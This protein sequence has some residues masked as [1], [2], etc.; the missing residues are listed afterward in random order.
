MIQRC[1]PLLLLIVCSTTAWGEVAVVDGTGQ[2]TA[3][4]VDG[5]VLDVQIGYRIPLTGW[6]RSLVPGDAQRVRTTRDGQRTAWT[7]RLPFG[8]GASCAVQQ[9][10]EERD[11]AVTVQMKFTADS[12]ID[13]EGIF[14]WIDIPIRQFAGGV[15]ALRQED[16][17]VRSADF[18]SEKPEQRH[19]LRTTAD[20]I[21][22]TSPTKDV[23]MDIAFDRAIDITAQDTREWHG[24][25]YSVF[26]RLAPSLEK[27]E[28]A[29]IQATIRPQVRADTSPASLTLRANTTRYRL[30]GFGGNYC[31]GI[32]S[33]VTQYT[34]R[35][36]RVA[37]ARTEMT[38]HE[39]EPEN[40]NDSPDQ[41]D[42]DYLAGHDKPD[43][44]LRREFLL[45]RQIQDMGVPYAISI[46]ALPAWLYE[47]P[48]NRVRESKRRI[49]PDKWDELL[50]CLGSYLEHAKRTYGVEP[51]LFSFNEAN[52]G[53]DVLLTA[54]EHREAIKRIGA[55]FAQRGLKTK[56]LLADATGPRD[57]HTYALPAANDPEALR[58]LWRHWVPL[59]GWSES[60]S[61]RSLG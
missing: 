17:T 29:S 4:N 52:I 15:C 18:P 44:N 56:M 3:L 23:T 30:D 9:V 21:V 45:A 16:G 39:W 34:L 53:V 57:T 54:E 36:L 60:G 8:P 38:P 5:E 50:E 40:D 19:F 32:E 14:F 46:W 51:D 49:H 59:V 43:S 22:M 11:G 20:G 13:S 37:W 42:W 55:H 28:S 7:G 2:I 48:P 33:P 47:N 31:F 12:V 27:G 41:T 1:L 61:V 26:C 25:E 24:A 35:N 58:V 6:S 10:I